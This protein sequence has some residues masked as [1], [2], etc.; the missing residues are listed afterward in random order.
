MSTSTRTFS[1]LFW[2]QEWGTLQNRWCNMCRSGCGV[3]AEAQTSKFMNSPFKAASNGR[4]YREL[5]SKH[6]KSVLGSCP[7]FPS[8]ITGHSNG[9]AKI[10]LMCRDHDKAPRVWVQTTKIPG[11]S[12]ESW[13][14]ARRKVEPKIPLGTVNSL[15]TKRKLQR[16]LKLNV[17]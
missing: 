7:S 9:L 4:K 8:Q 11:F 15:S 17:T 1:S 13:T 3:V 12:P 10:A 6:I 2:T 5:Y 16:K 14:S